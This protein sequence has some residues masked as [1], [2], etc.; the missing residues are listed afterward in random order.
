MVRVGLDP[1]DA[2]DADRYLWLL[3]GWDLYGSFQATDGLELKKR[4]E[5]FYLGFDEYDVQPGDSV[6]VLHFST[7]ADAIAEDST[8]GVRA[9][10][11]D[12]RTLD[13]P[14]VA[15]SWNTD[16]AESMGGYAYVL[17]SLADRGATWATD[18]EGSFDGLMDLSGGVVSPVAYPT[19]DVDSLS[20]SGD[21]MF[22]ADEVHYRGDCVLAEVRLF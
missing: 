6:P 21:A 18:G 11:D 16:P 15:M 22:G 17:N 13:G 8:D 1:D 20:F 12:L 5:V 7:L 3:D 14:H 4:F 10:I 19:K 9:A 2:A